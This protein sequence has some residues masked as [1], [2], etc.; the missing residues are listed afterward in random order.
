MSGAIR[1]RTW[2]RKGEKGDLSPYGSPS[3]KYNRHRKP[4]DVG[5]V[6]SKVLQEGILMNLSEKKSVADS[7]LAKLIEA[8]VANDAKLVQQLLLGGVDPNSYED[9]A[10]V[11]PL[12]FAA[13]YNSLESALLLVRAGADI[14]AK[15]ADGL[16]PLEIAEIN[17]YGDRMLVLLSDMNLTGH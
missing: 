13:Q 14:K 8:V 1:A 11:C 4:Q 5:C 12:H 16:T 3:P 6:V 15:T 9:A 10:K 7:D 17:L 2:P